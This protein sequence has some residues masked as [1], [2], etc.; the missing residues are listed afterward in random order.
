MER[1]SFFI[2]GKALLGSYPTQEMVELLEKLGVRC[3]VNLTNRNE[4]FTTPYVTKYKYL[5]YPIHDNSIPY[6]WKSFTQFIIEVCDIIRENEG[7]TYIHCR[8][9][10]F[11]SSTVTSII[12]AHYYGLTP[13]EAM[14]KITSYH[15][16]RKLK[17][18]YKTGPPYK[19]R[20]KDFVYKFFRPLRY[21]NKD[22]NFNNSFSH[23]LN[24][25]TNYEIMIP[26]VGTF[27]NAHYAFL[28]YK[29]INNKEYIENLTKGIYIK[30]LIKNF[31]KL[32]WKYNRIQ[33]MN[34]V[35]EYKF[36]QHP[37]LRQILMNT[38]LRPLIKLSKNSFWG[39]GLD[40]K[41]KNI[42][43]RLLTGL[44]NLFLREDLKETRKILK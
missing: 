20:Q 25:F 13:D 26:E 11:R 41:G 22:L 8:A 39:N 30:G 32:L 16:T 6:D 38:G 34:K 9:G 15:M 10:V 7:L 4:R 40:G 21:C 33:Y 1:C 42:H 27:P 29:D 3:F 24:N 36:N 12:L 2:E 28:A 37:Q 18:K 43:G 17:E 19:A 44:R 5:H 35:L 23:Y 14:S 31:D